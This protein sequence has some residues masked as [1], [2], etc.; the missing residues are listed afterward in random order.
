MRG[1]TLLEVMISLAIVAGVVLTV[2]G[3]VNFH[4]GIVSRERDD[5]TLTLLAR[6]RIAEMTQG[7]EAPGTGEGT[8]APAHPELAWK[9]EISP[10]D[11]PFLKKLVVRVWRSGDRREVALV[12]YFTP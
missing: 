9:S 5:T 12:R 3:A 8:F 4:L 11:V 2:I 6:A 7:N 10:T 1:F